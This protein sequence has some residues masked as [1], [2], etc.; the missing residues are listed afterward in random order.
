MVE[1]GEMMYSSYLFTTSALDGV[2]SASCPGHALAPG[3]G[4][5]VPL[6]QE[7][8]WTPQPD[9]KQRIEEKSFT[10]DGERTSIARTSSPYPDTILTELTRLLV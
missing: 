7:A 9:W 3:K 1:Q 4:P 8:G 5:P 10:S 6:G 2:R